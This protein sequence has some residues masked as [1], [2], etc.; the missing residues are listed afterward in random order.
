ML[1][2]R[3]TR[4]PEQANAFA[5]LQAVAGPFRVVA[6]AEGFPII[7][8]R[9]GQIEWTGGP[10][11]AVYSVRPRLFTKLWVIPGVTR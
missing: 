11:L 6:D 3:R 8:G 1:T 5:Q 7:P 10:K 4:T 2:M 9:Y